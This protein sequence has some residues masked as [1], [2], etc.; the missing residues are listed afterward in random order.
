MSQLELA[1]QIN[2]DPSYISKLEKGKMPPPSRKILLQLAKALKISKSELFAISG[3]AP[4]VAAKKKGMSQVFGDVYRSIKKNVSLPNLSPSMNKGWVRVAISILLVVGIASS[5]WLA[6]PTPVQAL[7]IDVTHPS[8]ATIGSPFQITVLVTVES[9]DILPIQSAYLDI[10]SST[11]PGT[12]K[13]R[14][15]NLPLTNGT[16]TSISA[17]GTSGTKGTVS[18]A[19]LT[20]SNWGYG[21]TAGSRSGYGYGYGIGWGTHNLGTG[22]GYGYGYGGAYTGGATTITYTVNWTPPSDW[23]TGA[24]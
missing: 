10:Q 22:Y 18:V 11:S 2:V 20:G 4:Y 14:C 24:T 6:S 17:L 9:A 23:P 3:K 19:A 15:T 1:K 13:A 5:L 12:Y 8:T 16:S 21:Y 7:T